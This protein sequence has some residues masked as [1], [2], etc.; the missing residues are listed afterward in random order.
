MDEATRQRLLGLFVSEAEENLQVLAPLATRLQDPAAL[1]AIEEFC[2]T[3][4]SFKGAAA[5][6]GLPDLVW[7]LHRL[8]AL[9]FGLREASGAERDGR[10]ARMRRVLELLESTIAAA[11]AGRFE[12]G[13]ELAAMRELLGAIEPDAV[14]AAQPARVTPAPAAEAPAGDVA[15]ERLSVPAR[16]VD[17][18]LRLAS[19]ISRLA[20]SAQEA[21]AA[22]EG[23]RSA[24]DLATLSQRLEAVLF[25]LRMLPAE[26]ALAGLDNEVRALA[27]RLGKDVR[28]VVADHH[29]RADRRTLQT[30]RTM[31]RHLV[32]NSLDHGFELPADRVAVGKPA[33]GTLTV[34][35]QMADA[36][37][38]VTVEDDGAGFDVRAARAALAAKG[39]AERVAALSD[40]EVLVEF[41]ASG[42]STRAQATDIS[43]RGVGLSTVVSMARS[44]GGDLK[45]RSERGR[46]SQIS[47]TLPLEVYATEVLTVQ[48]GAR[49]L[50]I[51]TSAIETT[52]SLGQHGLTPQRGPHGAILA[53]EERIIHLRHLG[54]LVGAG[55]AQRPRFAVIVRA[56]QREVALTVDEL[57]EAT[58]V[59]PHALA[60]F[61]GAEMLVTG[62]ALLGDG[63]QVHVL[64][65]R[66]LV[67]LARQEEAPAGPIPLALPKDAPAVEAP[68]EASPRKIPGRRL[69]VLL[70]E[71]SLATREVLRVLLEREGFEV[72]VA[73]DGEEAQARLRERLP[74]VLVSDFNMPVCDGPALARAV[75]AHPETAALPVILLTSRD[76]ARSRAE[77]A[78]AGADAYLIKSQFNA[79][80]LR[81]TLRKLGVEE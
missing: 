25:N 18:A 63:R 55:A 19:S 40:S 9:A 30:A 48:C 67:A 14:L 12:A 77:G 73:G 68:N 61:A 11:A 24:Q 79:Q 21:Q 60:P 65:P 45:L 57:G 33:H 41:A 42:G 69:S 75:R 38:W 28:V 17:E 8:E 20:A 36:S 78:A 53:F 5:A 74:D 76:D 58:R 80:L 34:A 43:G 16:E 2:G 62:V 47:F 39:S 64:N 22:G 7:V 72:R 70:A 13:P 23:A 66:H 46:G 35:L 51:P 27:Q 56:E 1:E 26:Q 50:G 52:V 44:K 6:V 29:V 4:H 10:L 81:Q 37:L 71:D 32:R 59:V 15:E 49:R 3:A 31:I 54:Q